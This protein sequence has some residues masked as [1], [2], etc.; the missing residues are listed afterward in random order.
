MTEWQSM[1]SAPRTGEE[2][3]I[4]M[5]SEIFEDQVTVIY[6]EELYN[7]FAWQNGNKIKRPYLL[8]GWMPL[9]KPP[10]D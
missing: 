6:W 2:F 7:G 10:K 8:K 1:D 5:S 4:W 3:I 9:P